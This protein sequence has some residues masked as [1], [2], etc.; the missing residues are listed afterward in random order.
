[1]S[2]SDMGEGEKDATIK[3]RRIKLT[4]EHTSTDQKLRPEISRSKT[5]F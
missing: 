2:D 3:E 4:T 1:V 5:F